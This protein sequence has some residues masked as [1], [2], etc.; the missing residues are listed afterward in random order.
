MQSEVNYVA[1]F[2]KSEQHHFTFSLY[3]KMTICPD[4]LF[5]IFIYNHEL[6]NLRQTYK[7]I[8]STVDGQSQFFEIMFF[9]ILHFYTQCRLN[10]GLGPF[11]ELLL[12]S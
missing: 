10:R 12:P 8:Q 1:N 9:P 4:S 7:N 5:Y 3:L 11:Y 6:L 2:L